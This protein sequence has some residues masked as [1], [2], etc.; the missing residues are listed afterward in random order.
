MK[1]P[2]SISD[3]DPKKVLAHQPTK[4]TSQEQKIILSTL[5][6]KLSHYFEQHKLI[7]KGFILLPIM[8]TSIYPQTNSAQV[9]S[10]TP[11]QNS[12]NNECASQKTY[13]SSSGQINLDQAI[14]SSVISKQRKTSK[15]FKVINPY[16]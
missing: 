4:P 13:K 10:S 2:T 14:S 11:R 3:F 12:Q 1:T 7:Y 5:S 9:S 16:N 6:N 8:I 15:S